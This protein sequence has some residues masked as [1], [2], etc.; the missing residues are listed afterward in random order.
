MTQRLRRINGTVLFKPNRIVKTLLDLSPVGLS[1]LASFEFDQEDWDQ[2]YQ[3]IGYTVSGYGE[4]SMVSD[5]AK[6]EADFRA[7]RLK[8]GEEEVATYD[9]MQR[10][11]D[12]CSAWRDECQIKGQGPRDWDDG[13]YELGARA[14]EVVGV[15]KDPVTA[16]EV[17]QFSDMKCPDCKSPRVTGAHICWNC[18]KDLR[19]YDQRAYDQADSDCG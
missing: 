1:K 8:E 17:P 11:W 15:W 10:L 13:I 6:N 16:T 12:A 7:G 3:L 5:R 18:G 4:L 2:F 9:Q 14:L 19:A